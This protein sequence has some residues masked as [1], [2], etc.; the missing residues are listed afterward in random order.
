MDPRARRIVLGAV[1]GSLLFTRCS[2]LSCIL[3]K[4]NHSHPGGSSNKFIPPV[5][6]TVVCHIYRIA[7]IIERLAHLFL[8]CVCSWCVL[9][10]EGWK[11]QSVGGW[12]A[13][14]C[15]HLKDRERGGGK[16]LND[17]QAH[18]FQTPTRMTRNSGIR[19]LMRG[20]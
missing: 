4:I 10:L 6:D 3:Q 5:A 2:L 17:L 12:I 14:K 9:A 20:T 8:F 18:M 16:A 15:V 11:Y 13:K 19:L 1:A 7:M